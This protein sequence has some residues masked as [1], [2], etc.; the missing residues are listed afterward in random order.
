MDN[1]GQGSE[2]PNQRLGKTHDERPATGAYNRGIR[3][4]GHP[5]PGAT[6]KHSRASPGVPSWRWSEPCLTAVAQQYFKIMYGCWGGWCRSEPEPG[7]SS[8]AAGLMTTPYSETLLQPFGQHNILAAIVSQSTC[9]VLAVP[10]PLHV[11]HFWSLSSPAPSTQTEDLFRVH[12]LP[13]LVS[14]SQ[15]RVLLTTLFSHQQSHWSD[16]IS[17]LLPHCR[18]LSWL[19]GPPNL[20]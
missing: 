3:E 5:S 10:T 2:L 14:A 19:A 15:R 12:I 17:R 1:V 20:T 11:V 9:L 16:V 7:S 18:R 8:N 13:C 4:T 6:P